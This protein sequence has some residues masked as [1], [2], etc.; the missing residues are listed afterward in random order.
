MK[1][2]LINF[3][4]ILIIII[5]ILGIVF[6]WKAK[7]EILH[8]NIFN[9]TFSKELNNFLLNYYLYISI[10]VIICVLINSS[11]FATL[12][13]LFFI[14]FAVFSYLN[15]KVECKTCGNAGIFINF[16]YKEEFIFFF[17]GLL[18]SIFLLV[19]IQISN[20]KTK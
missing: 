11:I 9:T 1:L 13:F 2:S 17:I 8:L 16:T 7:N 5:L 18:L 6:F 12:S 3:V 4:K 10:S 15:F 14:I 19:K 20:L